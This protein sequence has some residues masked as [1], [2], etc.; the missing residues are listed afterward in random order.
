MIDQ[1]LIELMAC[2][3]CG[4]EQ[5][6][7]RVDEQEGEVIV[8]GQLTCARCQ[9]WYRVIDDIPAMMPE[10]LAS[11][12]RAADSAWEPWRETME[13]F[14]IWREDA[15]GTPEAAQERRERAL[16]M[17]RAFIEFVAPAEGSICLDIGCGTGHVA[18]LLPQSCRY[19]GIDP[20]PGGRAPS[21]GLPRYMP[22]PQRE[23]SLIQGV[24]EHPPFRDRAFDVALLMG[25]LDHSHDPV[26]VLEQA[27]RVL[28]PGGT[29]GVLQ[30]VTH[31][32]EERV[33][34]G[35]RLRGLLSRMT[36]AGEATRRTHLHEFSE[37]GLTAL[38]AEHFTIERTGEHSRRVLI[39]ATKPTDGE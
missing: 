12:L 33:G 26:A 30:G 2:P 31:P 38:V 10:G 5:F 14:L 37:E 3:V 35:G 18:D 6:R 15:W 27:R 13:E 16:A 24:G 25:T 20:L 34:L 28:R 22:I 21:A 4:G 11:S 19:V 17:H 23:V 36:G 1:D 8:E 32:D 39:R 9:R 29:L 7:L